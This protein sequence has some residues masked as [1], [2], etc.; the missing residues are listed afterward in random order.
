MP[1]GDMGI[2]ISFPGIDNPFLQHINLERPVAIPVKNVSQRTGTTDDKS[3]DPVVCLDQSWA[4][5]PRRKVIKVMTCFGGWKNPFRRVTP[6]GS[7]INWDEGPPGKTRVM[8]SWIYCPI[9]RFQASGMRW[10]SVEG[11]VRWQGECVSRDIRHGTHGRAGAKCDNYPCRLL[12]P[13]DFNPRVLVSGDGGF[14]CEI[15]V[16]QLLEESA[17]T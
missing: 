5:G 8:R 1:K 16:E 11:H 2:L 13:R 12:R 4:N 6:D 9:V 10:I 15:E 3:S 14:H 7:R 17:S